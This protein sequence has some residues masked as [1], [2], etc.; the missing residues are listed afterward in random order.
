MNISNDYMKIIHL[1][2]EEKTYKEI[3]AELNLRQGE[4]Q[5]R[6]RQLRQL[7][8]VKTS[9]GVVAKYLLNRIPREQREINRIQTFKL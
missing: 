5:F 3:Q 8:G 4:L 2:I 7:F 1:L 9:I 6:M